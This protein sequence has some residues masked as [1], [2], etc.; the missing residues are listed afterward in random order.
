MICRDVPAA[1]AGLPCIVVDDV[2]TTGSTAAEATRALSERGFPVVAVA[3]LAATRR[4]PAGTRLAKTLATTD[5][6]G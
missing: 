6:R 4:Q 1:L 5:D 3:A 2:V